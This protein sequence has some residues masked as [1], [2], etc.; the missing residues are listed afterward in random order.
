MNSLDFELVFLKLKN[1]RYYIKNCINAS[2][3][4]IAINKGNTINFMTGQSHEYFITFFNIPHKCIIVEM[5]CSIG[6]PI[7][8]PRIAPLKKLGIE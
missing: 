3:E 5:K 7:E 6:L 4:E 8:F 2:T 1:L